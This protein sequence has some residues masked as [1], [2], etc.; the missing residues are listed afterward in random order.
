VI[1]AARRILVVG[2]AG[3]IGS[4]L[5]RD[6]LADGYEVRVLDSLIY[7]EESLQE[8]ASHPRFALRRGDFCRVEE[9]VRAVRGVDAVIHLGGIVGDMACAFDENQTLQTNVLA[10]RLLAE[11]CRAFETGRFLFASTCSVYGAASSAV[12]E[13]SALKPLSLYAAS[14]ADAERL[15][16][17]AR[18]PGF[19]PCIL[20]LATAFGWSFRPRFDLVVNLLAARAAVEKQIVIYNR[21]QWRP[22]IHVA[23]ISRA[24]RAVLAAPV[25]RVSGEIFNVGSNRMNATLG[26]LAERIAAVSTGLQIDYV[27]NPDARSYRPSFEKIRQALGFECAISLESGIRE[28]QSA[29]RRGLITSY[30]EPRYHNAKQ[31]SLRRGEPPK[32]KECPFT[33]LAFAP[34]SAWSGRE[35]TAATGQ[36]SG[37]APAV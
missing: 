14:K 32:E 3:Y 27:D 34:R 13:R 26:Q 5:V 8:L 2:G 28:I 6:L 15:L 24:F 11:V 7:G 23:D 36:T 21:E 19:H 4:V 1:Q 37:A 20:R 25:K 17:A 29:L 30:E 35:G 18:S 12:D 22:F 16:L 9:V 10:T 31:A 33:A